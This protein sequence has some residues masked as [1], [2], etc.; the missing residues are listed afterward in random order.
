MAVAYHSAPGG[1]LDTEA[2][3]HEDERELARDWRPAAALALVPY[4]VLALRFDWVCDD[5]FISFR[6]SRHL[7]EG[8]GLSF[9]PGE[10]PPVEGYSNLLWVLVLAPFEALG[11]GLVGAARVLTLASGAAL[12]ALVTRTATRS[13]GL[14]RAATTLTALFF[15]LLSPVSIWST[16]GLE[17]MPFAL[18][19]FATYERAL[20]AERGHASAHA[21]GVCAGLAA[22]LRADGAL[23]A[24][25]VLAAVLVIPAGTSLRPRMGLFLRALAWLVLVF[26]AQLAFRLGYHGDWVSNTARVKAGFSLLRLERGLDYVVA[27][28]L[29]FPVLALLV[30][31][32]LARSRAGA[33]GQV[34][35]PLAVAAFAALWA[36]YIGG[37]FMAMGRLFVPALAF[38]ALLF[39]ACLQGRPPALPA[40]LLSAAA[41]ALALAP[42]FDLHVVPRGVR[43]RFHFRW[44]STRFQSELEQWRSMRDNTAKWETAA[45]AL[46]LHTKAGESIVYGAVGSI[47]YRTELFVHDPLGLVSPEV[48]RRDAPPGRESAGHDRRVPPTWFL[49]REPDYLDAFVVPSALPEHA[50]IRPEWRRQPWFERLSVEREPL[51]EDDGFPAGNELRLLRL[52]WDR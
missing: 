12:L 39:A 42:S 27:F 4:L 23:W 40:A 38:F 24:G 7:A 16:S 22:L 21:A 9:N 34:L 48:A 46:A 31:L 8:T 17:T 50:G 41:L 52:D 15:A 26:L 28:F 20:A 25:V 33:V 6:Y 13:F 35:R 10:S 47:G 51:S 45:R 43:E 2:R 14:G 36:L 49:D 1:A 29:S 37:D 30:P 5:A 44:S 3:A 18:A 19:L 32:A 11:V